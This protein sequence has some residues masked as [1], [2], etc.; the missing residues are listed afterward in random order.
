MAGTE[1]MK[2]MCKCHRNV[3]T[4]QIRGSLPS[5]SVALLLAHPSITECIYRLLYRH[6]TALICEV[7]VP[8]VLRG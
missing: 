7:P 6:G 8:N 4:E 3:Y 2:M 1:A 5:I